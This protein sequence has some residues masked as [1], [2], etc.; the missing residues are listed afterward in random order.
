LVR[1]SFQEWA[2]QQKA[3]LVFNEAAILFET[4]AYLQFDA[5]VLVTA[6]IELRIQRVQQRDGLQRAAILQRIDNQWPDD[7]K[8]SLTPFQIQN[9]GQPL[10][11]QVEKLVSQL[12]EL[13]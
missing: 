6:P 2:S 9:D 1:A 12:L 3:P 4:G 13:K 11:I 7:Q 5:T 10:L 8:R